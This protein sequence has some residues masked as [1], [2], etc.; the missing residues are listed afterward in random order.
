MQTSFVC[1]SWLLLRDNIQK[2]QKRPSIWSSP[3]GSFCS[4]LGDTLTNYVCCVAWCVFMFTY[5]MYLRK[6]WV[7]VLILMKRSMNYWCQKLKSHLDDD[8]IQMKMIAIGDHHHVNIIYRDAKE[9]YGL[10]HLFT[11]QWAMKIV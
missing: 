11:L 5:E 9:I 6:V 4:S 8:G 2:W 10:L 1:R 7:Q 3:P